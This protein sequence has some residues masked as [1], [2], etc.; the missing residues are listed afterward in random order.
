MCPAA[1]GMSE[2]ELHRK[3]LGDTVRNR[4]LQA[5]L[6][7]LIK[8]GMTTVADIGAGT[9]FL[10]F[11]ARQLGAK[12][13]DLYEY[14]GALELA[15]ALARKNRITNLSFIHTHSSEI[16]NPP[17]VDLVISETLGNFALEENLLE[18][19]VDARRFLKPGGAMLP[20][21]LKQFVAPVIH[22]RLQDEI[23]IWPRVGFDLDLDA[24]R[25][26]SLNNMYV[27]NV[28]A[29]DMPGKDSARLWDQIDFRSTGKP[30]ASLR[31]SSVRWKGGEI[32]NPSPQP[33]PAEPAPDSIRGGGGV[34]IYGFAL[35]WEVELAPGI[36]ISTS[37]FAEPT[38]WDQ[39]YLP[40]LTPVA[41]Q[42][43]DVLE[44]ELCSDTR[45][46]VRLGWTSRLLRKGKTVQRI[47]QN[48]FRGRL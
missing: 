1:C 35:W 4:A 3:L 38:H 2:I 31:K 19:L 26:L 9:G 32:L 30:P 15:Q 10:S 25:E 8:P 41:P 44:L 29:A 42:A 18:T 21:G 14:S 24:A 11:L 45:A 28:Q 43:G 48:S 39:I 46:D 40:L 7:R 47:T 12:H 34:K 17:K 13:C 33:P 22:Q 37:P 6:K 20:C 5:A 27:K 23:D 16:R 36:S